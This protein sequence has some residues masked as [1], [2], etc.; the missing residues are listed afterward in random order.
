MA[1]AQKIDPQCLNFAAEALLAQE[2]E[3]GEQKQ[4]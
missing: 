2:N 4:G 1:Q 3:A